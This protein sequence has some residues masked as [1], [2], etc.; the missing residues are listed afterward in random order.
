LWRVFHCGRIYRTGQNAFRISTE[1]KGKRQ[2][3]CRHGKSLE[4]NAMDPV[5]PHWT[6]RLA[7]G[8]RFLF[9]TTLLLFLVLFVLL[10]FFGSRG[11]QKAREDLLKSFEQDRKSRVIAMIHR[12]ESV[13]FLGVPV[14]NHISIEDSEAVLRAI[15]F[16]PPDQPIDL[17]LHTPGGLV[18]AA[19]QITKALVEH[20]GKVTVFIPHY[21]MSGGTLIALAADEIV[22]DANAVLGPVDPQI[23]SMPAASIIKLLEL[24]PTAQI[25]DEMLILADMAQKARLQVASFLAQ[26][27]L[28][29]ME[30]K[31]AIRLATILSEGR[32]THD[33]PLP[34]QAVQQFGL[35]VSTN[36]PRKVYDIMDLYPQGGGGRPSVIYIP[37]RR[38]A[39]QKNQA[40]EIPATQP[41]T[42]K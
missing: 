12:Q 28:K 8:V 20:K 16:T 41:D 19:E 5:R 35:K 36:M 29:H 1:Y 26:V 14:S 15:R 42:G 39:D 40:P 10:Q 34:V 32:W 4:E 33:F 30:A 6:K 3:L 27:L 11:V 9:W 25:S 7:N 23:G 24:K 13:S 2:W 37:M 31:K 38:G 22:M 21:A 17:I 18:L